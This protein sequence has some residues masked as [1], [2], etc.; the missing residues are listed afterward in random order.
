MNMNDEIFRTP[1]ER[2]GTDEL[3]ETAKAIFSFMLN[4][5]LT[6]F[7]EIRFRSQTTAFGDA[8][9]GYA[10][11][12]SGIDGIVIN[13]IRAIMGGI[14]K[15]LHSTLNWI[16]PQIIDAALLQSMNFN[17]NVG[18]NVLNVAESMLELRFRCTQA[19]QFWISKVL[20]LLNNNIEK[21]CTSSPEE[22]KSVSRL[23]SKLLDKFLPSSNVDQDFFDDLSQQNGTTP[24]PLQAELGIA[25]DLLYDTAGPPFKRVTAG[26]QLVNRI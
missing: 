22:V 11:I 1:L 13:D 24:N 5:K 4:L 14:I 8:P 17:D 10:R 25:L 21:G 26:R 18:P 7:D 12:K 16:Y 20:V 19:L 3:I 15:Y 23:Y 6:E 2:N 9:I